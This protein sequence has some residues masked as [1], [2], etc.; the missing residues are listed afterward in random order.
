MIICNNEK[1]CVNI[2]MFRAFFCHEQNICFHSTGKDI[3]LTLV[4]P[5]QESATDAFSRIIAFL[6]A[7]QSVMNLTTQF[8]WSSKKVL[9]G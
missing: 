4:F 3:E 2:S 7:G 6:K 1:E 9:K 5:N 8:V